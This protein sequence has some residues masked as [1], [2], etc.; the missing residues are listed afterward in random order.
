MLCVG[1]SVTRAFPFTQAAL[2]STPALQQL[3]VIEHLK[4]TQSIVEINTLLIHSS[5]DGHLNYFCFGAI[6]SSAV[7]N[8]D[9]KICL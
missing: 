7:L 4:Y 2:G 9:M 6:V 3:L 5:A 8:M 1:L